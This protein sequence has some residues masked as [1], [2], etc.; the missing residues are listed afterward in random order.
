MA[1]FNE[2]T[3]RSFTLPPSSTESSKLENAERMVREA[4]REDP[5]LSKM[6]TE[7]FG[8]GSY[9]NDTNVRLNS[10]VDINVRYLDVFYFDLPDGQT[11]SDFSITPNDYPFSEYKNAVET[12]LVR[13]FGRASVTRHDKCIT[14]EGNSYRIETDVVPTFDYRR[15]SADKTYARGTKFLSDSGKSIVNFPIQHIDNGKSKNRLTEKKF[16]RLTRIHRRIRYKMIEDVGV[17]DSITSFLIECLVWNVPNNIFNQNY[18][19]TDRLKQSIVHLYQS[20]SQQ[21]TCKEWGE[22]SELLYLFHNGRKW[23]WQDVNS[24]LIKMWNYLEY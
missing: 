12:A 3:L 17:D 18:L 21:E 13:K 23:T 4:L 1:R 6:N 10:D 11:H 20:T 2:D 19:W 9:S 5:V 16:K 22:V 24:Y 8:Q 14:V 15:Y 7:T